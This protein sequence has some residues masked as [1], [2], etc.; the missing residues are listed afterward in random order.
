MNNSIQLAVETYLEERRRLGFDLDIA[1]VQLGNFA[2]YADARGHSGP[3]TLEVQLDWARDRGSR[4]ITW[5]RRLE[6]VRPFARY[7]RQFEAETTVPDVN[8]F[9]PGHRRLVPH[10]YTEREICDLLGSS[11]ASSSESR[12]AAGD[13]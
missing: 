10:I 3:L 13:V 6:I 8:I 4:P 12:L 5:A 2:R 9:G 1:G 11:R 7:Y